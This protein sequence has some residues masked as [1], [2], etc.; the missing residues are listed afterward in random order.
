FGPGIGPLG[1]VNRTFFELARVIGPLAELE[2]LATLGTADFAPLHQRGMRVL[3]TPRPRPAPLLR[4]GVCLGVRPVALV[5]LCAEVSE[6]GGRA[7]IG[8][9]DLDA[10]DGNG[11]R[12]D[13]AGLRVDPPG[14]LAVVAA[15][16]PAGFF[17]LVEVGTHA[18]IGP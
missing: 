7:G 13:L 12:R 17:E 2:D 5:V 3:R 10:Q 16:E 15:F 4:R 9:G 18:A 14:A 8:S 6:Q 1:L 11:L